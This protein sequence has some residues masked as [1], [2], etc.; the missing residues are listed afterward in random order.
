MSQE[1]TTTSVFLRHIAE[2][3]VVIECKSMFFNARTQATSHHCGT[4][5]SIAR[6]TT[7]NVF[8]MSIVMSKR[9]QLLLFMSYCEGA[10][11][12]KI[13]QLRGYGDDSPPCNN[14]TFICC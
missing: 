9:W 12:D 5:L 3:N 10:S 2:G 8:F 11:K 4:Q 7:M 14:Q 1:V 13:H 6:G